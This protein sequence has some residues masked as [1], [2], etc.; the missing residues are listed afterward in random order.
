MPSC[1]PVDIVM[2]KRTPYLAFEF[3]FIRGVYL[4]GFRD[5]VCRGIGKGLRSKYHCSITS[6]WGMCGP[7]EM[8]GWIFHS[9]DISTR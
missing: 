4:V 5:K 1:S 6:N 3:M 8:S 7:L 9:W 2:R